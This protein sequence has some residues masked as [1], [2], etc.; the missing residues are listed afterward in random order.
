MEARMTLKTVERPAQT[1]VGWQIRTKPQ[2]PEIPALWP[3]FVAR[4][5]EISD[6]AEPHV[7]YGAMR[8]DGAV[9][10]YAAAVSVSAAGRVPAGMTAIHVPAGT[11]AVF[12]YP[13]SGLGKGF[14]E[15]NNKLLPGSGYQPVNGWFFERYDEKFDP[16]IP[17][18]AVGI[19]IPVRAKA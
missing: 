2:S 18:S 9:L 3:K 12:S 19:Y 13:L 4:I 5:D 8:Y 14:A 17:Q 11:Y 10:E 7:S 15:I 6:P 1:L 16:T